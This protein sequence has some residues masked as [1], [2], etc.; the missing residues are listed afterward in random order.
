LTQTRT[1]AQNE[2]KERDRPPPA[3][4][5]SSSSS[6]PP[7]EEEEKEEEDEEDDDDEKERER[8]FF[9][10][11]T[12]RFLVVKPG[13]DDRQDAFSVVVGSSLPR[14]RHSFRCVVARSNLF[15]LLFAVSTH[16]L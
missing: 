12:H 6:P 15:L 16:F 8:E 4:S 14:R 3:S 1:K 9:E 10:K 2:S 7:S 11:I 13:Q 5:S